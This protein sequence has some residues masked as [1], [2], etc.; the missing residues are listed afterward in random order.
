DPFIALDFNGV[1]FDVRKG[2]GLSVSQ[3]VKIL[4]TGGKPFTYTASIVSGSEWL[5]LATPTGTSNPTT[6]GVI[7]LSTNPAFTNS[8]TNPTGLYFA[9]IQVSS[10]EA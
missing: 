3:D 6:F 7:T 9:S 8:P 10:P 4:D 5:Q 2:Q 1:Q